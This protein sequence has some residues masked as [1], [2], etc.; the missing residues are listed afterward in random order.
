MATI[1][2]TQSKATESRH[3]S[4]VSRYIEPKQL[5]AIGIWRRENPGG[6][7]VVL[8]RKAVNK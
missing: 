1:T 4:E 5:S 7:A 2:K 8:D 6:I 3:K